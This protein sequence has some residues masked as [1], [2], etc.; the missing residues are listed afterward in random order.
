M[1]FLKLGIFMYGHWVTMVMVLTAGLGG[2]SL[3]AL[4]YIILAFWLL[5]QG[6]NLYTMK[7]YARTLARWNLLAIYTVSVMFCKVALQVSSIA[8]CARLPCFSFQVL[9]C[10]FLNEVLD[11]CIVRQLFSIVCVNE[12]SNEHLKEITRDPPY[13]Q[14]TATET[15]IGYDTVAFAFIIFQLR[16]LHSWY[17][18]HCMIDFRCE[19]IQANRF[20]EVPCQTLSNRRL[21]EARC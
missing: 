17:F 16:I 18:Q 8:G 19:I 12:L 9:G 7:N 4:G 3:F 13:C 15:K 6:N 14:V 11:K 10:V 1:D 20:V 2:T 5:W 21:L